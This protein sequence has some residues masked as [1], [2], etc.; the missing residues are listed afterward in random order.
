MNWV[1][2]KI[3][4]SMK[5]LCS[6]NELGTENLEQVCVCIFVRY[7]PT[8]IQYEM[9]RANLCEAINQCSTSTRALKKI[10][11]QLKERRKRKIGSEAK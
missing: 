6:S 3:E 9:I 4:I 5:Q 11:K 1:V 7:S 10:M 8:K 2:V